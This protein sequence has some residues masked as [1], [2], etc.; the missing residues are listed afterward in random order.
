MMALS[1]GFGQTFARYHNTSFQFRQSLSLFPK[2]GETPNP[3]PPTPSEGE[4]PLA[5]PFTWPYMRPQTTDLLTHP[6]GYK[7]QVTSLIDGG[8]IFSSIDKVLQ[9]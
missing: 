6:L 4:N 8:Q 3:K 1:T 7:T 2:F 9:N 5:G